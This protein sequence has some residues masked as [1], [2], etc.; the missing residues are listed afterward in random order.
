MSGCAHAGDP[1]RIGT[2][3]DYPPFS[4]DGDGFDV[5]VAVRLAEDLGRPI[6]WVPFRWPTLGESVAGGEFDVAMSGVT[7]RPE[8][9]VSGYMTRAVAAS[10]PCVV[11]DAAPVRVAVNR[12]GILEA[13]TREAF[14][15]AQVVTTDENLSLPNLLASGSA[16]AFVTDSVEVDHLRE[17]TT[18]VRCEPAI[19]RK[20][21]WVTETEGPLGLRIDAWLA[22]NEETLEHLRTEY[23][24]H[25]HPRSAS[26]HLADLL[27]RR[28]AFMPDVAAW[29]RQ[30]GIPIEDRSRETKVLAAA[31]E[32]AA[33]AGLDAVRAESFFA[34]QIELAKRIQRRALDEN[35]ETGPLELDRIR[36]VLITIGDRIVGALAELH[37]SNRPFDRSTLFV[38]EPYLRRDEIEALADRIDALVA[39][40]RPRPSGPTPT[41]TTSEAR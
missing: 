3:G 11:G 25:P 29:K 30:R 2:S 10:G 37:D 34:L 14:P 33:A 23:F 8:R 35:D 27:A 41:E 20:V 1:I 19:D 7:W 6:E 28:L 31:K 24:G 36:P 21:Y 40:D 17:G 4:A 9:A 13:W 18:A 16:D 38:L 22:D 15:D 26:D 5:A 39:T 12:G 32:A